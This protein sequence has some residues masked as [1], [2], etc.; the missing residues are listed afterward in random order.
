MQLITALLS[1]LLFGLGLII[2][3]MTN[4]QKV[5]AFLDI[6]GQW[7]P[8]LAF[9]ML[10][11]IPVMA[12]AYRLIRERSNTCLHQEIQVPANRK[13]D[14][15]LIAGAVLFG[16]GWG[17]VGYCPGPALASLLSGFASPV[18]FVLAMVAGMLVYRALARMLE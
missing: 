1:G 16:I 7:D 14:T 2:S 4:P 5:L 17:L 13:L 6:T 15:K 3:G 12:L 18:I 8:S 9:V 10:G 11:A